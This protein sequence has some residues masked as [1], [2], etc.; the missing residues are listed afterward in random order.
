MTEKTKAQLH[1]VFES[2]WE[3]NH[4][5]TW[6]E[7]ITRIKAT[8]GFEG[9]QR[10]WQL[11]DEARNDPLVKASPGASEFI[12]LIFDLAS[13]CY[14]TADAALKP[15]F[16]IHNS[17]K[18]EELAALR[19]AAMRE[20]R[21]WVTAEWKAHRTGYDGNKSEFSRHYSS[22]LRNERELIVT[23]RNIR[24]RWLKGL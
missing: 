12:E 6:R 8:P 18:A 5:K 19:H 13:D 7:V 11:L 4:G 16:D 10:L 20:A 21:E 3:E 9:W 15:L 23:D 17:T 22:R 1:E 14:T 24:E 2:K